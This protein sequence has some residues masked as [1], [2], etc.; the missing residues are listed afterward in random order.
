MATTIVIAND[1]KNTRRRLFLGRLVSELLSLVNLLLM[2]VSFHL[3]S[4][5][6]PNE[7]PEKHVKARD[8][9]GRK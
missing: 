8:F 5:E 2:Y 4:S 3:T 1:L 6:T 9:S 7:R